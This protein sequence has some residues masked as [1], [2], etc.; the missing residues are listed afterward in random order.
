MK[1]Y[2]VS[3]ACKGLQQSRLLGGYWKEVTVHMQC[4][5]HA[6][7]L[8]D[9]AKDGV[10]FVTVNAPLNTKWTSFEETSTE[11]IS[12]PCLT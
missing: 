3:V 10:A 9:A 5:I 6:S 4:L 1:I 2:R 7:S 11:S 12:L 8:N